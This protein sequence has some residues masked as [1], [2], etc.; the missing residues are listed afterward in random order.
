MIP[1]PGL[2]KDAGLGG[3]ERTARLTEPGSLVRGAL[4]ELRQ[5]AAGLGTEHIG[6]GALVAGA[7]EVDGL[8]LNRVAEV[9]ALAA[10]SRIVGSFE[11]KGPFHSVV[12]NGG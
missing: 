5:V 11:E 12:R 1:E 10:R 4:D 7:T 6:E 2:L 3:D 9:P 8:A